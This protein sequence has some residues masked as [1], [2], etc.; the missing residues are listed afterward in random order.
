MSKSKAYVAV[1]VLVIICF[2]YV[3]YYRG[4]RPVSSI[5]DSLV[6]KCKNSNIDEVKGTISALIA[7]AKQIVVCRDDG[8]VL[9]RITGSRVKELSN[10]LSILKFETSH[11]RPLIEYSTGTF[12]FYLDHIHTTYVFRI[13]TDSKLWICDLHGSVVYEIMPINLYSYAPDEK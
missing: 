2:I 11:D 8:K 5:S 6:L 3:V 9:F 7:D 13:D 10:A 12:S 4:A 1:C